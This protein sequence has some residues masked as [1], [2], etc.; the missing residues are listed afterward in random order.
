MLKLSDHDL[1]YVV[2]RLP[3]D[4]RN[5]LTQHPRRLYV[6]GGFIRA[7]IAGET[8]SDIDMFGDDAAWLLSVAHSLVALRPGAKMHVTKNAITVL[9]P[10]RL[11]VQF[12]TRWTFPDPQALIRSF[13]FTVCQAAI[14]RGGN[15]SNS[16]WRSSI[17]DRFYE[18]L[19]ARR[20]TYTSP[21]REE[22][23]GGSMLRVLKYVKRG[24]SIQVGS[25]GAVIA[26]LAQ[27][28][29]VLG[30]VEKSLPI[31]DLLR[32]VDPLLVVDGFDI[33]DDHEPVEGE[34]AAA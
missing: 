28:P 32:E 24:Y 20:L 19:A 18:D 31:A 6:G 14:W 15:Q 16:P 29:V 9:T 27:H 13:D 2:Q 17:D 3:R 12:I 10:D 7:T 30:H 34:G 21:V 23:A 5:L 11:S 25:L 22:E 8:P 26:R 1:R 33:V 4:V